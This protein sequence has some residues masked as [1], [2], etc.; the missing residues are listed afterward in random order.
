VILSSTGID[1]NALSH[2]GDWI[3]VVGFFLTFSSIV[4][5]SVKRCYFIK[6][7]LEG[8]LLFLCAV[9]VTKMSDL[10]PFFLA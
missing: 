9:V 5:I 7:V 10:P 6:T 4:T 3:A 1:G 2:Y 8:S